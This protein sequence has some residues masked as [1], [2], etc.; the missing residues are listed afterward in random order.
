MRAAL[1]VLMLA[2]SA[3]D[4]PQTEDPDGYK[5]AV[6]L[7]GASG[8]ASVHQIHTD[9]GTPCVVVLAYQSSAVTCDWKR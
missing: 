8:T 9:N 3:C 2:L 7:K 4:A 6:V 1:I 5:N